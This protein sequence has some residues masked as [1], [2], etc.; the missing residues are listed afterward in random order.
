MDADAGAEDGAGALLGVSVDEA[1]AP[2][3]E[4]FGAGGAAWSPTETAPLTDPVTGANPLRSG[5]SAAVGR[6]A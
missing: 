2:G 4:L 1:G 5:S 6:S 3:V